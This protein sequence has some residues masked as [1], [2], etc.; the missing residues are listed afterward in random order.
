MAVGNIQ[1][2]AINYAFE[3][4]AHLICMWIRCIIIYL[5]SSSL[6]GIESVSGCNPN[7]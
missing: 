1:L 7:D 2:I 5:S 6:V 4:F 3:S